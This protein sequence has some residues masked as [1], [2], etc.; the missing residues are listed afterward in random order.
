MTFH[1][2]EDEMAKK[3]NSWSRRNFVRAMSMGGLA[4]AVMGSR[5]AAGAGFFRLSVSLEDRPIRADGAV[6]F[7][8]VTDTHY[9]D[10]EDTTR[11][12]FFRSSLTNI[13]ETVSAFNEKRLDFAVH[14]GDVTQEAPAGGAARDTTMGWLKQYDDRFKAFDGPIHYAM[15]NHD[16]VRMSK[17]DFLENT[18]GAIRERWFAFD[19]KGYRFLVLDPNFRQDGVVPTEQLGWMDDQL[20]DAAGLGRRVIVF[21]HQNLH[22]GT[23]S[24]KHLVKN[25]AAVNDRLAASGVVDAVFCGHYHRPGYARV[26]GIHYFTLTATVEGLDPAGCMVHIDPDGTLRLEGGS[27]RQPSYGPMPRALTA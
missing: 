25:A 9:G 8:L 21:L 3:K 11:P 6:S 4:S 26:G 2:K 27:A 23:S 16:I 19:R 13:E 24:A 14:L 7:G 10:L 18:S 5:E 15:G 20:A 12:R 22:V 1:F 17:A